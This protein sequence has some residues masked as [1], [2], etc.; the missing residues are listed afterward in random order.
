MFELFTENNLVSHKQS[1]L[2]P[3]DSCINHH[4]S[5]IHKTCYSFNDAHEVRGI[6]LEI[7]KCSRYD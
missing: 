6:L 7:Q 4:A 5:I 1:A 2:K 3:C